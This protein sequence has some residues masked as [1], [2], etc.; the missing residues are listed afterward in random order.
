MIAL[1]DLANRLGSGNIWHEG[2]FPDM[3][4]G[5]GSPGRVG[6]PGE[7]GACLVA[8]GTDHVLPGRFIS[9]SWVPS[10]FMILPWVIVQL[11][12]HWVPWK[13][14]SCGSVSRLRPTFKEGYQVG[15]CMWP[16]R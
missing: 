6:P 5:E 12:E 11:A 7:G 14:M 3:S 9:R 10:G 16:T 15:A 13:Q 8:H 2:G 1:K 4:A